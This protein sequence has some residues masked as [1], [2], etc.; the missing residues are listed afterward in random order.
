MLFRSFGLNIV[1]G[2]NKPEFDMMGHEQREHDHRYDYADEWIGTMKKMWTEDGAFDHDGEYLHMRN[3][4]AEP[5]MTNREP[6]L[7]I[8]AGASGAGREFSLR[9]CHGFFTNFVR[10]DPKTTLDF[11][12]G[13]KDEAQARGRQINVDRKSTR[14]NSSHVSESR[15]PSSA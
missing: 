12:K 9:H 11:V 2:W 1:V 14:L 3:V 4:V 5:K 10:R 8:N 6:P 15:M 13:F 7:L